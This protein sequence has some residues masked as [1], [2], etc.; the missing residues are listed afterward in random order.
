MELRTLVVGLVVVAA[1]VVGAIGATAPA[2]ASQSCSFPYTT[3]DATG[4]EVT[5]E[6]PPGRIVAL[7]ASSAQTL[8][9]IGAK[10]QVVGMPVQPYTAYLD[11]SENRTP[12]MN[13]GGF[14]VNVEQVVGLEPDL[15]LAPNII[16][17]DT[18]V[19]LREAGLTVYR[20]EAA[21]SIEDVYEKT[22]L[23]GRLTN[24]CA[25]AE[26]T[27]DWM[28][29]RIDVVRQAVEGED[30]PRVVFPLGGGFIAPE[31]SF[32]DDMLTTAGGENIAARANVTTYQQVS[33][34]V[35]VEQDPEWIVRPS[36]LP[37]SEI[38]TAAYN[39]T[40]AV[41]E[42]QIVVVDAN[43]ANQPAP[44]IVY[45]IQTIAKA[46]HPEAYAAANATP[47]PSET[48]VTPTEVVTESPSPV[49]SPGQP[50]F[51]LAVGLGAILAALVLRRR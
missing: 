31:G 25:G 9:E 7:G 19:R 45:P 37:E 17:E 33:A 20:F 28:Q 6:S 15:V 32:V 14:T 22:R 27:V 47:T 41:R 49:E 48:P 2:A 24:R 50:G 12:I 39:Q 29:G 13:E 51:G 18:V 38:R 36:T 21:R 1:A 44:R 16:P 43:L 10:G 35:I 46:L 34:E 5:V 30:R 4:A 42:D 8:W 23:T 3:T 26:S 40:T 11:G